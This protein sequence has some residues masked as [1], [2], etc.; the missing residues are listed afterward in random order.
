[1]VFCE[2]CGLRSGFNGK[3]LFGDCNTGHIHRVALTANRL[4]IASQ[5]LVLANGNCIF[6]MERGPNGGVYFSD[7][8]GIFRLRLS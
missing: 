8:G 2:D 3:F 4:S 7:P 5:S 1:M 6:S